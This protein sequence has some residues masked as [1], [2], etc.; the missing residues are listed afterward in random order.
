MSGCSSGT[1]QVV[2]G[3][4]LLGLSNAWLMAGARA[5]MAT[6]WPV[7]DTSGEFFAHFYRYLHEHPAA[8]ALRLSQLEAV[9]SRT[10]R[11]APLYWAAYQLTGGYRE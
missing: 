1:G 6:A 2:A 4:G 9:H 8:E 11:A 7:E 10:W 3:A 5:V